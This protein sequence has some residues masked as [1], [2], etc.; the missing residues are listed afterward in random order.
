MYRIENFK[1]GDHIYKYGNEK[2][3][4]KGKIVHVTVSAYGIRSNKIR[5]I[6]MI[7]K[8]VFESQGFIGRTLDPKKHQ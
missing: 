7:N 4:Y 2:W 3:K 8:K 1:D 5:G 6:V